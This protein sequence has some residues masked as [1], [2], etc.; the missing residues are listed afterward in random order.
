MLVAVG[1]IPDIKIDFTQWGDEET[2]LFEVNMRVLRDC[3]KEHSL[4]YTILTSGLQFSYNDLKEPLDEI[5]VIRPIITVLYFLIAARMF[6][7]AAIQR[8]AVVFS[9]VILAALIAIG[10]NVLAL[11]TFFIGISKTRAVKKIW[12]GGPLIELRSLF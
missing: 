11:R 7:A 12:L 8:K 4:V 9:V 10:A 5:G 3:L 1:Y 2:Q 6:M